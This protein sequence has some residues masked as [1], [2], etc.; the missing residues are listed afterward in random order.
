MS[1][2]FSSHEFFIAE[3]ASFIVEVQAHTYLSDENDLDD[4]DRPEKEIENARL[5]ISSGHDEA[6]DIEV[7]IPKDA[8][9]Q[10]VRIAQK[11]LEDGEGA[12]F[13]FGCD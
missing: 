10:L 13:M 8:L 5:L 3:G 2:P 1:K 12:A 9:R 11:Y 6:W 4:G 7:S